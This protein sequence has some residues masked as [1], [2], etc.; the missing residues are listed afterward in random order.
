MIV[1]QAGVTDL[2]NAAAIKVVV[3]GAI[4]K[5]L[6]PAAAVTPTAGLSSVRSIPLMNRWLGKW[7]S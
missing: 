3:G 2:S 4:A 7:A 1:I 5:G 6:L